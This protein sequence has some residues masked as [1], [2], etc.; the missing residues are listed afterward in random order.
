[1]KKVWLIMGLL[2]MLLTTKAEAQ[3]TNKY[4]TIVNPVRDRSLWK[5]QT[6]EPIKDQY[7]AIN[8]RGMTATWLLQYD[9]LKDKELVNYLKI[10]DKNQEFGVF[11][12]IS[13]NL[14][15]EAR[16]NYQTER[17]WYDPGVV[18]LSGYT[19]SERMK[20]ID[21]L[22]QNFKA[23]FGNYPK[24][25]GAWWI[26]SYSLEY[27]KEK[28]GLATVMIVADQKNADGYGVWGQWWG[29]PYQADKKNI[30]MPAKEGQNNLAVIQ[31]AQRD[32]EM[33]NGEGAA[34]LFSMQANDYVKVKKDIGYFKKLVEVYLKTNEIGQI[35]VGLETGME[36]V[37]Q[38]KEYEKQLDEL[39]KEQIEIVTMSRWGEIAKEKI[40]MK[41]TYTIGDFVMNQDGRVNIKTGENINYEPKIVFADYFVADKSSFLNRDLSKTEI[42][43][44]KK[45]VPYWLMTG[46]VLMAVGVI[47]K[48]WSKGIILGLVTA[49]TA[50]GWILKANYQ[51]G[52]KV[53][54]GPVVAN[55]EVVQIIILGLGIIF[56][57]ITANKKYGWVLPLTF[58]WD[59]WV[60]LFRYSVIEEKY[61]VGVAVDALRMMGVAVGGGKVELVNK[62]LPSMWVG[63]M[64]KFQWEW[65]W[66]KWWMWTIIYPIIHLGVALVLMG[67]IKRIKN[68]T[69]RYGLIGI[70]IV[71]WMGWIIK[72][73]M[74]SP[75]MVLP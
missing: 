60:S 54:F 16:V 27:I 37:G 67:I 22:W 65:I 8:E 20:L 47:K 15:K 1:M 42:N 13:E 73:W 10:F 2:G 4:A 41:K 49:I 51:F 29:I 70:M 57:L 7:A 56:G 6:L 43:G 69:I 61:F 40:D 50:F 38:E 30:L 72:W 17:P 19:R 35:T 26:D 66:E 21:K 53:Y 45:F 75:R 9:V 3:E 59:W 39:K 31:W 18:F 46:V 28:Y 32:P 12:E 68:K 34:S 62:D 74:A 24:P 64:L 52:W 23:E 58:G 5:D 11:L 36:S 48:R 55:L 44:Q 71:G 63:S 25:V 33:G 14:A